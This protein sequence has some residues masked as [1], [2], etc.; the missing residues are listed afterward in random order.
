[1]EQQYSEKEKELIKA[2]TQVLMNF[3]V[4]SANMDDIAK[5][6]K[7]SKKTL[8]KYFKD[9]SDIVDKVTN[10]HCSEET[11]RINEILHLSENA[12]DEMIK[13]S[14]FVHKMIKDINPAAMFDLKKYYPESFVKFENH[15]STVIK[16][17]ILANL[18][19]GVKEGL[20]RD[21]IT[22]EIVAMIYIQ[23]VDSVWSPEVLET[24]EFSIAQV[25]LEMI[26][27]HVRGVASEKGIEYLMKRI[28]K[29]QFKL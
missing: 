20:Y 29:E 5:H 2:I 26:R 1:M 23:K 16:A 4:R 27:Y 24:N 18:K 11:C 3:G 22:P 10:L 9:K 8:Y 15:K 17:S 6:L 14:E 13:I 19:R 25:H 21:N 28:N 7:M 12:I